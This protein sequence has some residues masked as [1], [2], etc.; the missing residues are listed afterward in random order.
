MAHKAQP[1]KVT[2]TSDTTLVANEF[3]ASVYI[4]VT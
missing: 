2:F 4:F 3:G 1:D